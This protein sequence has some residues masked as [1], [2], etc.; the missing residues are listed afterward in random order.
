MIFDKSHKLSDAQAVTATAISA[1]VIEWGDNGTIYGDSGAIPREKGEG[2][3]VP[4]LVQVVE[5][6]AGNTSLTITLEQADNAGLSAG[7]EVLWS[8]GA[9]P[10]A[11]L[12]AGYQVPTKF[13]PRGVSKKYLG[14]R[15]AVGGSNATAGKV[16]AGIVA[17]IS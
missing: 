4:L 2:Y 9:I 17:G 3:P 16:T 8:S 11:K 6:F 14:L 1:N 10:V 15:Y 7:A 12:K 5:N 13:L